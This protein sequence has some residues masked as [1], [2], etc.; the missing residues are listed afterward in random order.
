MAVEVTIKLPEAL[1]EHANRFGQATQRDVGQVLADALEMMWSTID[2][3]SDLEPPVPTLSDEAI[4]ALADS[5]M[6]PT[7]N[8]RLGELQRRGKA[9]G[10]TE[11]ERAELQALLYMYQIGQLRKSEGLAEAVRRGLREPLTS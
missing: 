10:L 9:E 11:A 3:V 1:V 7:Q 4:L 2:I 6:D 5:K 8:E